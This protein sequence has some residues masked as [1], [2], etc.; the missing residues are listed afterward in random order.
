[1]CFFV[2]IFGLALVF[3]GSSCSDEPQDVAFLFD[4]EGDDRIMVNSP[5]G[6]SEA[7][8]LIVT[9]STANL[10]YVDSTRPNHEAYAR[11][12]GYDY[13]HRR[14]LISDSYV[15]PRVSAERISHR[16]GLYL[17][18][19][20][21]VKEALEYENHRYQYVFWL[22]PD[23]VFSDLERSL[24]SFVTTYGRGRTSQVEK[25]FWVATDLFNSAAS[26]V[27]AGVF[28]VKNTESGRR[29]IQ[30]IL[31]TFPHLKG[32]GTPEQL[33]IQSVVFAKDSTQR[34]GLAKGEKLACHLMIRR[35]RFC[36]SGAS[37]RCIGARVLS[38]TKRFGVLAIS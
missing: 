14:G 22:D 35:L 34:M 19:I 18:K 8:Y 10:G 27:N 24:E 33:G 11:K 26:T 23:A 6:S 36:L 16:W 37:I 9:H 12:H 25:E 13:W 30:A 17:Q 29:R 3:I 38:T 32:Y 15:D 31:D 7:R 1:M 21:A 4:R 28:M 2:V 5:G 20:H